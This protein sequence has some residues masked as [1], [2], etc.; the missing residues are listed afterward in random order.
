MGSNVQKVE[1]HL[2]LHLKAGCYINY[3]V[4]YCLLDVFT[5]LHPFGIEVG[6]VKGGRLDTLSSL[7]KCR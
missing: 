6:S 3:F 2:K 5:L 4:G 1:L 7:Y